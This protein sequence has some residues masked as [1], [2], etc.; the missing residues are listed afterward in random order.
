MTVDNEP[1][2]MLFTSRKDSQNT[3]ATL[4]NRKAPGKDETPNP[5][6]KYGGKFVNCLSEVEACKPE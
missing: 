4:K 5:Y 2:V 6:F 1:E 3:L